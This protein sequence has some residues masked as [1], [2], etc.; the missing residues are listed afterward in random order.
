MSL[1]LE[2]GQTP[3]FLIFIFLGCQMAIFSTLCDGIMGIAFLKYASFIELLRTGV[4]DMC[5]E[6][7]YVLFRR[8][9]AAKG[10]DERFAVLMCFMTN[11]FIR[12]QFVHN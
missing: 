4:L 5:Q 9:R 8:E 10:S 1:G 6:L 11:Y 12:L 7:A 3:K 2:W